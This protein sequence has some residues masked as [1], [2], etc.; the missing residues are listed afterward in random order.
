MW[1]IGKARNEWRGSAPDDQISELAEWLIKAFLRMCYSECLG[2]PVIIPSNAAFDF[3]QIT[4][5]NH[6]KQAKLMQHVE[7]NDGIGE[8][9]LY[10]SAT[11]IQSIS[12]GYWHAAVEH[13]FI[14]LNCCNPFM[15]FL[16]GYPQSA[17]G[18]TA[19]GVDVQHL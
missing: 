15:I 9:N 1:G 13:P 19:N 16:S 12:N 3:W 2:T 8:P 6:P 14:L 4:W 18:I 5:R 17:K 10:Y 7:P 11:G